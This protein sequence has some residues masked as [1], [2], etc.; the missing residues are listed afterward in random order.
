MASPMPII[1]GTDMKISISSIVAL[2]VFTA[3]PAWA[4]CTPA[5]VNEAAQRRIMPGMALA[6]VIAAI[7]CTPKELVPSPVGML[8]SWTVVGLGETEGGGLHVFF[9]GAGAAFAIYF[10]PPAVSVYS[11]QLRGLPGVTPPW[12]RSAGAIVPTR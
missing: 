7:G 6:G 11:S 1:W 12:V 4:I 9:D 10:P 2:A 8:A 3:A 5:Q